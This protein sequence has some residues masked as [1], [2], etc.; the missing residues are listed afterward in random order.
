MNRFVVIE[1]VGFEK[2][3][4]VLSS[5]KYIAQ[6]DCLPSEPGEQIGLPT[7]HDC[8]QVRMLET[9]NVWAFAFK[10]TGASNRTCL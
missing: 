4:G 10:Q 5:C 3:L 1:P 8:L 2:I 6:L 7:L 9:Q